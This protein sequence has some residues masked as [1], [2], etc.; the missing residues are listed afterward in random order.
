MTGRVAVLRDDGGEFELRE[1]P[2]PDVEPG[3]ILVQLTRAGIC[4]SG[5]PICGAR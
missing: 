4:G 3:A 2:V 1:Y 5:L